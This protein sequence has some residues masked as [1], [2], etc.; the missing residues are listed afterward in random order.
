MSMCSN[1]KVTGYLLVMFNDVYGAWL[2]I[3]YWIFHSVMMFLVRSQI[4]Y[5]TI[6]FAAKT[7]IL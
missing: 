4:L 2:M 3:F 6:F 5:C 7:V 1:I